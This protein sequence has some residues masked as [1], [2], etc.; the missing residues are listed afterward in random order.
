MTFGCMGS[1]NSWWN[2]PAAVHAVLVD[3][4]GYCGHGGDGIDY[5]QMA[6]GAAAVAGAESRVTLGIVIFSGVSFTTVMTGFVVPDFY[7]PL[8]RNTRSRETVANELE[9]LQQ[10]QAPTFPRALTTS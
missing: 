4:W 10:S 3:M 7:S 2:W 1:A 5:Q 6:N 8:A 9:R